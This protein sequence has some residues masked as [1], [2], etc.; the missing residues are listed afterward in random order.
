MLIEINAICVLTNFSSRLPERDNVISYDIYKKTLNSSIEKKFCK[1]LNNE[2]KQIL[3]G[4][5]IEFLGP[6]FCV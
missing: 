1:G 6:I 4:N 3:P 5:L 2:N